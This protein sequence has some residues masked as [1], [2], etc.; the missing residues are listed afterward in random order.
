MTAT[1]DELDGLIAGT[2]KDNEISYDRRGPG[3]YFLSLPGT[4]KLQTNCWLIVTDHALLV[5]AFVCRKPDEAF[6][7]VYRFLL[8]RNARLSTWRCFYR[9]GTTSAMTAE[10]RRRSSALLGKHSSASM[11]KAA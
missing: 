7:D 3:R 4:K 2:L 1:L 6:E 8:R 11:P 10:R 9:R 5:E